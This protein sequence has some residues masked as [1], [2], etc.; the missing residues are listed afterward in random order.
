MTKDL[1]ALLRNLPK[2]DEIIHLVEKAGP[3]GKIPREYMVRMV[4]EE[5]QETRDRLRKE[6]TTASIPSAESSARRVLERLD[7]L[8][9]PGLRMVVNAT[10]IVLHTNLG[11]APLAGEALARLMEAAQGYSNLEYDLAEG[12]GV[13]GTTTSAPFCAPSRGRRTPSW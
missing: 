5:V 2:I 10:G 12:S 3:A 4:R 7:L 11:R 6:G 1:N 13:S 9:R 8:G